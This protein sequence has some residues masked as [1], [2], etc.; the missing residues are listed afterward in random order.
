MNRITSTIRPLLRSVKR[1][2]LVW[3]LGSNF[4][5][6]VA[7]RT[8]GDRQLSEVQSRVVD[9]LNK[10]GIYL[11]TT[12]EFFD[13]NSTFGDIQKAAVELLTDRKADIAALKSQADNPG[14]IGGKTFNLECL[15]STLSF[16]PTSTFARFALNDSFLKIADAY[17]K[18]HAKLRY[19]N[20]WYTAAS[21]S[22]PRESQLWHFDREDHYILKVFLYLDDVDEGGGP[23]TYAPG[24]HKKGKYC[25]IKPEFFL[26]GGVRRS[27][28]EQ[29]NAVFPNENWVKGIGKTGTLIFADTRGFHKGGEARTKDRLM[30]TCMYTSHASESRQ[31]IDYPANLDFSLLGKKE[32]IALGR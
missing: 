22:T 7:Y 32:R 5:P 1:N 16:D 23:F 21:A 6:T 9:G 11:T 26:E 2:E 27:T 25:S 10:N 28:D 14:E 31:L 20:L 24:T 29:M 4:S 30:Y 13:E 8:R 19:Y 15:G 17:L 3:R 12:D 18:M